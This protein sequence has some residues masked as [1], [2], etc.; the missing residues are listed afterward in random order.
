MPRRSLTPLAFAAFTAVVSIGLLWAAIASGWLGPDVGRGDGFCEAARDALIE[1][2]AN[3]LSNGGFVV[4]GLV[5]GWHAGDPRRTIAENPTLATAYAMIVVLLGPASAA[6]HATQSAAGG[7][8]DLL[9][10][11]LIAAFAF[12]YAATRLLRRGTGTFALLWLVAIAA[13]EAVERIPGHVPVVDAWANLAFGLLLVAAAVG[14]A[15]LWRR[16][17]SV[18]NPRWG[19]AAVGAMGLAFA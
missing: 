9:S 8:L 5:I 15:L 13:C 14:E 17:V 11:Y 7:H 18:R 1:Q 4:A 2:P 19:L 10:M 16:G 6:M 3:T 12:G